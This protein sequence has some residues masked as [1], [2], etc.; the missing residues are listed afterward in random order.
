MAFLLS[1][2]ELEEGRYFPDVQVP[3]HDV[4]RVPV[5]AQE[6][7]HAYLS[8]VRRYWSGSTPSS[9]YLVK[10][11]GSA[12]GFLAMLN[13]YSGGPSP[14]L[15]SSAPVARFPCAINISGLDGPPLPLCPGDITRPDLPGLGPPPGL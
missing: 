5:C 8:Y 3:V 6:F 13:V 14:V 2:D 4:V 1:G 11:T 7:L 10:Q 12:L 15:D 9:A